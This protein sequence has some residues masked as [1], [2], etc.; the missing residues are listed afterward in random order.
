MLNSKER[1]I[2]LYNVKAMSKADKDVD[3]RV[4]CEEVIGR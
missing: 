4:N 1:K 2:V 3:K